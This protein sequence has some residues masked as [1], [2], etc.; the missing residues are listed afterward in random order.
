MNEISNRIGS[1]QNVNYIGGNGQH[2]NMTIQEIAS[3]STPEDKS[4]L[5]EAITQLQ[6][7]ANEDEKLTQDQKQ[8]VLEKL[9]LIE[10]AV[11]EPQKENQQQRAKKVVEY[12]ET[13][14]D[15]LSPAPKFIEACHKLFPLITKVF[16]L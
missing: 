5:D 8:K 11:I 10:D 9:K 7:A 1:A 2:N 6:K 16:G 13:A 4:K 3:S 14:I 15:M 12:L